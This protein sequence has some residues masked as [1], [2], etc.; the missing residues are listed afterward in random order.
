[1]V[2]FGRAFEWGERV[3]I[4]LEVRAGTGDGCSPGPEAVRAFSVSIPLRAML[5][6]PPPTTLVALDFGA[7]L[8]GAVI[9]ETV[10]GWRGMGSLFVTGLRTVD[11]YP[12]LGFMVVVGFSVII[13]NLLADIAYAYL[14]P[15]IRLA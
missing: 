6:H 10:F 14:D 15:R 12:V 8:A 13:F 11:P 1:M 3:P 4:V 7:I 9:T 5:A 2:P